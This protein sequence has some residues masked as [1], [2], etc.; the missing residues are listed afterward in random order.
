MRLLGQLHAS[1]HD[2]V[3]LARALGAL[4]TLVTIALNAVIVE[5]VTTHEVDGRKGEFFVAQSAL[6]LGESLGLGA[7][8]VHFL[9]HFS[10]LLSVLFDLLLALLNDIILSLESIQEIF[11]ENLKLEVFLGLDDLEDQEWGEDFLL[12]NNLERMLQ[13][14]FGFPCNGIKVSKEC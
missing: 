6:F 5:S 13:E 2:F 11:P 12:P 3:E 14:I 9:L 8:F 10:N 4:T 1:L 7:Q